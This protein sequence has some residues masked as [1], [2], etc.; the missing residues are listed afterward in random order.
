MEA[1]LSGILLEVVDCLLAIPDRGRR[2]VLLADTVLLDRAE[3][4]TASKLHLNQGQL[5]HRISR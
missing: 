5:D 3:L 1:N 4:L 2:W